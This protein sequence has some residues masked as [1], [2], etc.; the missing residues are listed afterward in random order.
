MMK[1]LLLPAAAAALPT[2]SALVDGPWSDTKL[3]P[4]DRAKKLLAAM[5]QAEKLSMLHGPASGPCW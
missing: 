5:T 2:V 3:T 4:E 1:R